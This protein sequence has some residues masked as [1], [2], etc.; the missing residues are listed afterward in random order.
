MPFVAVTDNSA[1]PLTCSTVGWLLTLPLVGM[2]SF[3]PR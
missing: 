3:G 2:A 1:L